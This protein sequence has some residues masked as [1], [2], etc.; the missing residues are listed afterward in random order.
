MVPEEAPRLE[1][2]LPDEL[3]KIDALTHEMDAEM[4]LEMD[5]KAMQ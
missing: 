2:I 3:A 1:E 4:E 5:L